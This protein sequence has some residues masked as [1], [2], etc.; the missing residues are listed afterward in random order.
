MVIVV[1]AYLGSGF[2]DAI[3]ALKIFCEE[4]IPTLL[5]DE[6]EVASWSV[7]FI[8]HKVSVETGID[9]HLEVDVDKIP[10]S[11]DQ[12]EIAQYVGDLFNRVATDYQ[13]PLFAGNGKKYRFSALVKQ[14]TGCYYFNSKSDTR[15]KTEGFKM[16]TEAGLR[17][18]YSQCGYTSSN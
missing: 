16:S 2:V 12:G 1:R 18:F 15:I 9:I 7:I 17:R 6:D 3:S 14:M 8:D 11:K 10:R 13:R 4:V 5:F